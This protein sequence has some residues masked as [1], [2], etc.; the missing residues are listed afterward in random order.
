[1]RKVIIAA[2][3][4]GVVFGIDSSSGSVLWKRILGSGWANKVGARHV[5]LKIFET[6]PIGDSAE[7]QIVLITQRFANNVS[8]LCI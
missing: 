2:T 3:R 7:P 6:N 4:H 5:P 8:D 1:M